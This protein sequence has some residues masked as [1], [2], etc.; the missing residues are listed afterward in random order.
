MEA[1]SQLVDSIDEWRKQ[2]QLSKVILLGHSMGGFI[3]S[4]YALKYPD[5]VS[6]V[7]LADPWGFP[8]QP[9]G[10]GSTGSSIR[11]RIPLWIKG[12]AYI[13]QP[14][15]PLWIVRAAGPLGKIIFLFSLV[16]VIV[17]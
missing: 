2:M 12:I 3:A 9:S 15:N 13:L 8:D 1:E 7:I 5:H 11:P 4:A 17:S 14:F 10:D 6:H 16:V